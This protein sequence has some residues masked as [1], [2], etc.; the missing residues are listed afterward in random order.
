MIFDA[1]GR[2]APVFRLR[3]LAEGVSELGR[4]GRSARRS[5]REIP[6]RGTTRASRA[7]WPG[8]GNPG[9]GLLT[10]MAVLVAGGEGFRVEGDLFDIHQ[11]TP[12]VSVPLE[13]Y[14]EAR[15]PS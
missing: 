14:D 3:D 6:H 7:D 9:C 15:R 10:Q 8:C 5:G 12:A 11:S 13:D 1:D 2:G 4:P